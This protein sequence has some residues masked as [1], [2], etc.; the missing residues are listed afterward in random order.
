MQGS[1][2]ASA[3]S[4][5]GE[6]TS[7]PPGPVGALTGLPL[8]KAFLKVREQR[9]R[10]QAEAGTATAT[11]RR[12]APLERGLPNTPI[13]ACQEFLLAIAVQ[14]MLDADLDY[15]GSPVFVVH[16][17]YVGLD[18]DT[19][20]KIQAMYLMGKVNLRRLSHIGVS[21]ERRAVAD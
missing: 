10:Q 17:C 7:P 15:V 11:E 3:S 6:G 16:L 5:S 2:K 1:A 12:P 20:V 13:T 18:I 19:A 8:S 4:E 9:Q 21:R 14:G